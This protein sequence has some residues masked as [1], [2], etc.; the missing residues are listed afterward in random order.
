MLK[1]LYLFLA[2]ANLTSSDIASVRGKMTARNYRSLRAYSIMATLFFTLATI[3]GVATGMDVMSS[4]VFS[5]ALGAFLSAAVLCLTM[6]AGEGSCRIIDW[7]QVVFVG[8]LLSFG[9]YLTLISS[10]QQLTI[11]LV[12]MYMITPQLFI[13]KP[14]RVQL[15]ILITDIIFIIACVQ[16]KP[17]EIIPLEITDCVVYS[18]IG[19]VT[20]FYSSRSKL[21]S[22]IY[23]K[24]FVELNDNEQLAKYLKSIGNI[25]VS[26]HY[27]DLS[28]ETFVKIKSNSIID[29]SMQ[30]LH[31][32]FGEQLRLVMTATTQ[33]NYLDDVLK[34]VDSRTLTRRMR[35]KYTITHEFL[36]KHI[37]WCR[38]RFIAV[39]NVT[40]DSEPRYVLFAVESI[41]EQKNR[42][43]T[44]ITK[45][46]TDAMT[47]LLNRQAGVDRITADIN[48]KKSGMLC[49]FD[50]DK[51][52]HVNDTYG[53]QAGDEVIM[54]V[55]DSMRK[56]FRDNDILLRLGGD[57]YVVYVSGVT[58]EDLGTQVISR[59]FDI[60]EKTA[61]KRMPDYSI[62]I[63]LGA[64]FYR[65]ESDLDF[66]TLY[67]RADT[68]TYES[69]KIDGKAFTFWR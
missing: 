32:N 56:A 16:I 69:K 46:E 34:F 50:V 21:K 65:G 33:P 44:L 27:I 40:E 68:C 5:Y 8:I 62:S 37:G 20:G 13:N 43:N 47:G 63:S 39:G 18:S 58:T 30:N 26:M 45:A 19:L 6:W 3:V 29:H 12:A 28:D 52:K 25:Y 38:A 59:F 54:A 61:L 60:L 24:R 15:P 66:D 64:A 41:N 55:A 9:L 36:G 48:G 53:H 11:S 35:G 14:I 67:N 4:K 10:P 31:E 7:L 57:E 1:R 49:L 42:E 23:E 22:L 17:A 51:F 2:N